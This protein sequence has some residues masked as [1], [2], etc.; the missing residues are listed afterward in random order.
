[1]ERACASRPALL[2]KL[3]AIQDQELR[4]DKVGGD[5]VDP[6][7]VLTELQRGAVGEVQHGGL[8]GGVDGLVR[9]GAKALYA[10]DVDDR[11]PPTAC[12][13]GPRGGLASGDE[14]PQVQ[15]DL[16]ARLGLRKVGQRYGTRTA[17][18]IHQDV[19]SA[20]V[21]HAPIH[22]A[23]HGGAVAHAADHRQGPATLAP[24]QGGYP[25][26]AFA[27]AFAFDIDDRHIGPELRQPL[28]DTA[29]DPGPA[30]GDQRDLVRQQDRVPSKR[31]A[32][33]VVMSALLPGRRTR[34]TWGDRHL[35]V[36]NG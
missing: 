19:D 31:C 21:L 36:S 27:F 9:C 22:R 7:A 34:C 23:S 20:V 11:A 12:D 15:V 8:A 33:N 1:M 4:R 6:D 17:Y 29:A 24:D 2:T 32:Q 3:G 14:A 26:G 16:P 28:R 13:H 30:A 5:G 18:G 25:L 35:A 10:G